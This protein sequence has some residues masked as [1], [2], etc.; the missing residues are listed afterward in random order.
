MIGPSTRTYNVIC[1]LI[2]TLKEYRADV[3]Y[4]LNNV[5]NLEFYNRINIHKVYNI[6]LAF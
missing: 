3:Y 5:R 1:L 4:M 2:S 6:L